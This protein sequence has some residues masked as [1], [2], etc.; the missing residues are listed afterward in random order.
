MSAAMEPTVVRGLNAFQQK[1]FCRHF[2]RTDEYKIKAFT[3]SDNAV[4]LKV[5]P[6]GNLQR[7]AKTMAQE[8][9]LTGEP[10]RLPAMGSFERFVVHETIKKRGGLRTESHGE[11]N[12]RHVEIHPV[13][14]RTPRKTKRKL[15]R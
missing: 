4:A 10:K 14:G 6:V 7:L 8:V 15:T 2:G 11:E 12:D 5:Y 9:L 1:Q 13:Y 3:E